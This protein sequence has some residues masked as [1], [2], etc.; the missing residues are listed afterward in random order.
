M[1]FDRYA[2]PWNH[3][4]NQDKH[5]HDPKISQSIMCHFYSPPHL[6]QPQLCFCHVVQFV[7][8][9]QTFIYGNNALAL[10][11]NLIWLLSL[12]TNLLRFSHFVTHINIVNSLYSAWIY[13]NLFILSPTDGLLSFSSLGFFVCFVLVCFCF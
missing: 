7:C 11:K 4:H 9:F 13:H 3:R 10:F 1:T 6:R 8:I 12:S 5:F 2:H